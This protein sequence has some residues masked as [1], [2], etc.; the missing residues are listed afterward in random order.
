MTDSSGARI[1]EVQ[2]SQFRIGHSLHGYKPIGAIKLDSLL[3]W[4]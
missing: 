2:I 3:Q 4:A 1:T